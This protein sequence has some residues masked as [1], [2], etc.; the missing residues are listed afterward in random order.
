[1]SNYIKPVERQICPP[2]EFAGPDEKQRRGRVIIKALRKLEQGG[3][4]A[5]TESQQ[6]SIATLLYSGTLRPACSQDSW[7]PPPLFFLDFLHPHW[8]SLPWEPASGR[9]SVRTWAGGGCLPG[10]TLQEHSS[11]CRRFSSSHCQFKSEP[12]AAPSAAEGQWGLTAE[13]LQ[14]G[15]CE[16]Q[17]S[18]GKMALQAWVLLA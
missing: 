17:L 1:M 18:K 14:N 3:S 9:L 16:S 4:A 15:G 5:P 8:L 11:G 7:K 2:C 10:M 6:G 13:L 12:G